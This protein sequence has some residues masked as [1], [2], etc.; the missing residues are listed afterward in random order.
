MTTS[1]RWQ[2]TGE[3]ITPVAEVSVPTLKRNL[4][5]V[6]LLIF[7]IDATTLFTLA[8]VAWHFRYIVDDLRQDT[9]AYEL[10]SSQWPVF[11]WLLVLLVMGAW[12]SRNFG[13]SY[14]EFRAITVGSVLAI[15][16]MCAIGFVVVQPVSRGYPLALFTLGLPA[17]LL[18]RYLERK[19]L[20]RSRRRGHMR[21]RVIAVGNP[22]A[23]V[24]VMDVFRRAPWTGYNV[25]GMCTR[26]GELHGETPVPFLGGVADV[27]QL[28]IEHRADTVIVLSGSYSSAADLKRLGW[29]LEGLGVDMLVVPSLTDVAGPRIHMRHVAGLPLV[30]VD[31]PMIDAAGG[32]TKRLFDIAA[33]LWIL[34]VLALPMLVVAA[35]IKLQDGGSVFYRQRRVGMH[36]VDFEMVKFRSMVPHADRL[37]TD[38]A[39][40]NESDVLFKIREDPRITRFGRFMRKYSIDEIPQLFN[41]IRGEMSL[42]GPRPPLSSEVEKYDAH[43]HRRLLV[44]PGMTGLWQVSGRSDLSWEESVRLDLYY[45]DNWS[46]VNDIVIMMKTARAVFFSSG[47]Y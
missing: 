18:L 22:E 23:V 1:P 34:T 5:R 36:G 41:V 46:M 16:I 29:G 37:L 15:G 2:V 19:V 35:V 24:D 30:H 25:I 45:V 27:R 38:L 32:V 7:A 20:H 4:R 9:T 11:L 12:R 43:V 3:F 39:E 47:A 8:L 31:E 10:P 42:V 33:S 21:H 26:E 6:M 40:Q 28:V 17:L 44:R 14:E 13:T